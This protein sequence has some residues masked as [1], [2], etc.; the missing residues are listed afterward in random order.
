M[1]VLLVAALEREL[2][3]FSGRDGVVAVVCGV[4]AKGSAAAEDAIARHAPDRVLHVGFAG[5]LRAGLAE[6][7]LLLV[8]EVFAAGSPQPPLPC[9]LVPE[10]RERLARLRHRLGQG[11]LTTVPSFVHASADKAALA[12]RHHVPACDMEAAHI[13]ALCAD[14]GIPYSGLRAISDGADRDLLPGLRQDGRLRPAG[15][16]AALARPSAPL[17]AARMLRGARRAQRAL[18]LA[19][20]AALDVVC[21]G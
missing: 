18:A 13:A 1:S 2:R 5:A 6:G 7:D 17:K 12:E 15:L 21:A 8:T 3:W 14:R 11:A 19:G 16:V 10:L 9:A 20:P 4:G